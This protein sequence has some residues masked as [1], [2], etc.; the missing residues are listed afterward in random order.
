[1]TDIINIRYT[2][3]RGERIKSEVNLAIFT[4]NSLSIAHDS[5]AIHV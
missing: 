5:H 1:M 4:R 3:L 2:D